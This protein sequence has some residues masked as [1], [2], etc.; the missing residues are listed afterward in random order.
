MQLKQL[1]AMKESAPEMNNYLGITITS[2][3]RFVKK[4][5]EEGKKL[6]EEIYQLLTR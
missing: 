2:A 4:K 5:K 1:Q 6:A 3:E